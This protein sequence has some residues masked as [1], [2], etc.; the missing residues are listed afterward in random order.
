MI[1]EYTKVLPP[2][3]MNVNFEILNETW[4]SVI[5]ALTHRY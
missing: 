2:L 3:P 4:L 1:I 5:S